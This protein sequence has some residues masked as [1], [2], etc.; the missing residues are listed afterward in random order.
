M[1]EQR[2]S[3]DIKKNNRIRTLRCILSCDRISSR[4]WQQSCKTAGR[5][6]CRTSGN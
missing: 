5:L 1:K 4:N 3:R 2:T 6:F